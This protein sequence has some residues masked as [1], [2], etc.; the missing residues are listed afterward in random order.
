MKKKEKINIGIIGIGGYGKT[1]LKSILYGEDQGLCRLK[2]AVIRNPDKYTEEAADLLSRGVSIYRN[3]GAM[4]VKEEGVLDLIVIVCGIHDHEA[5]SITALEHGFNV[6][7]E[8]PAAGN[9]EQG[10][11]MKAARQ[12]SG[13]ILA[14]GYQNIYSPNIQRIKAM[15]LEHKL[16]RLIKAKGI[17]LSP[18]NTSYYRRNSWAGKIQAEG[19][20]VMDSPIQNA[21]SHSLQNMLYVAGSSTQTSAVPGKIYGECY[22]AKDIESADTQY[23]RV[24]TT[25]G[26][27][28]VLMASHAVSRDREIEAEY[29]YEKG[30]IIWKDSGQTVVYFYDDGKE[31]AVE[32]FDNGKVAIEFL[33]YRNVIQAIQQDETPLCTMDN[34]FSHTV[35]VDKLFESSGDITTVA[36]TY[37]KRTETPAKEDRSYIKGLNRLMDN[38]YREEKS[39]YDSGVPWAVK[40][41]TVIWS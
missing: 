29:C 15:T 13:K 38:M 5:V 8:K 26:V 21:A 7:C 10:L 4:L 3:H 33:V 27:Q 40:S 24:Q 6:L 37:C 20:T 9:I 39:F 41:Q 22:R 25:D 34:A 32:T 16:G 30:K 14:I 28:I 11:K 12:R 19:K 23:V 1:H 36:E 35:C 18:R 2:A 31:R 17:A